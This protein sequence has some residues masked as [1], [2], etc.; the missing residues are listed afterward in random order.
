MLGLKSI[1]DSKRGSRGSRNIN[2]A[3]CITSEGRAVGNPHGWSTA[4]MGQYHASLH[5]AI[6]ILLGRQD[7]ELVARYI[8]FLYRIANHVTSVQ[9]WLKGCNKIIALSG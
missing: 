4:Q 5:N 3:L 8:M 6:N 7:A 2:I 1:H 9:I